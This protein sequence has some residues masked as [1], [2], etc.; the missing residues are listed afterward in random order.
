MTGEPDS[1]QGPV[2]TEQQDTSINARV[3]QALRK[4]DQNRGNMN[5][6][7]ET[8]YTDNQGNRK[9]V[10]GGQEEEIAKTIKDDKR[11]PKEIQSSSTAFQP[12]DNIKAPSNN[13]HVKPFP[14]KPL[15]GTQVAVEE[16]KPDPAPKI[17]TKP[18]DNPEYNEALHQ[19]A[20]ERNRKL[21]E[22]VPATSTLS[23]KGRQ[24]LSKQEASQKDKESEIQPKEGIV[25]HSKTTPKETPAQRIVRKMKATHEEN[26][27][28]IKLQEAS[29]NIDQV[30]IEISGK[31]AEDLSQQVQ[32]IQNQIE[33]I[34]T[35]L[36]N[37]KQIIVENRSNIYIDQ[38]SPEKSRQPEN[39]DE[40]Q[41]TD[42]TPKD[43]QDE[44]NKPPPSPEETTTPEERDARISALEKE[45][46]D[47]KE[48]ER[49]REEKAKTRNRRLKALSLPA[50]VAI[51]IGTVALGGATVSGI[52]TKL[53]GK[54]REEATKVVSGFK[55]SLENA[56]TD[57]DK[58]YYSNLIKEWEEKQ[59][60]R[61]QWWRF[62]DS[63][64]WFLGGLG[65]TSMIGGH[66]K[67]AAEQAAIQAA[68]QTAQAARIARAEV[69]VGQPAVEAVQTGTSNIPNLTNLDT[70]N[71]KNYFNWNL[72]DGKTQLLFE[73]GG[74]GLHGS[75]H[76]QLFEFLRN[77]GRTLTSSDQQPFLKAIFEMVNNNLPV[78]QA[79]QLIP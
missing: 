29:K 16:K 74:G 73:S 54:S 78:E 30:Y 2:T 37:I 9:V 79:A 43:D 12:S 57:T 71:V 47:M 22:G 50:T 32:N 58:N 40:D 1:K 3:G 38:S 61:D 34:N 56:R 51:S 41:E 25:E 52:G 5:N 76:K 4:A 28:Y 45:I 53:L 75:A 33:A 13:E 63:A 7:G 27:K 10:P 68:E 24:A 15:E 65:A 18:N 19:A 36:S 39:L 26:A 35:N 70:I 49:Q 42:Q 48:R 77:S 6:G 69:G 23:E 64:K 31:K 44:D 62:F 55:R 66:I 8:A 17:I 46:E 20:L 60:R 11:A 21:N 14:K 59:K 72:A 67:L